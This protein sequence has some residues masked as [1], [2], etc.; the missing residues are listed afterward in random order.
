MDNIFDGLKANSYS[1][2]LKDFD[3]TLK[4]SISET[5]FLQTSQWV[6]DFIGTCSSREYLGFLKKGK[7]T[8]I[9]WKAK[10]DKSEDDVLIRLVMTKRG[11]SYLVAGIW[12][13]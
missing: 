4:E 6:K 5:K 3:E 9:L 10:C 8:V 12:F 13:Q 1:I 2:Y 7:M 11:D